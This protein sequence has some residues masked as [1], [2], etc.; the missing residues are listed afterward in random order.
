[1]LRSTDTHTVCYFFFRDNEEQ[2]NLAM[3]LCALLHQLF[4]HQPQLVR[5]AI[6][7]WNKT[8][9]KLVRE[10]A[11]LWRILLAAASDHQAHDITFVLDALDECQLSNQQL[12]IGLLARFCT[13]ISP[14][15]STTRRGWLKFLI[16]SRPYYGVR[17]EFQKT[18]QDLPTI[19][20][21]G[22]E[23]NSLIHQEIDLTIRT[24]VA[25]LA[26]DLGLEA[27]MLSGLEAKLLEM[28]HRTYLWL[29][30]TI[31]GIYDTFR[32][33]L[34]PIE[35]LIESLPTSVQD[36]YERTLN[37]VPEQQRG[38]VQKILQIVVGSRRPLTIQEMAIALGIA[39]STHSK[40]V[41]DAKLDP[42]RLENNVRDWCGLFVFINH[43]RIHLIH[44]TAKEFLICDSG[45]TTS[46]SGW[47]HCL[48]P[49]GI[50]KTMTQICVELLCLED[51]WPTGESIVRKL[52][53][54]VRIDEI[55]DKDND[56][57]S[58]LSYAAEH[59]PYHLRGADIL[60]NEFIMAKISQLCDTESPLYRMWFSIFWR[61]T[62]VY[63]EE[64]QMNSIR[65][66]ALLG[67]ETVLEWI[68]RS[69][70]NYDINECDDAGRTALMWASEGGHEKVVRILLDAGAD[71]NAQGG[72]YGNALQ[73]ASYHGHEKVM[74]ILLDVGTDVNA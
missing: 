71:V 27:K 44:Q 6:P 62:H 52:K 54:Y 37:R 14:F 63:D 8:G 45:S 17:A 70:K 11:E 16:T 20:I 33:S 24:M 60:T 23:E 13:Q 74:Q 51:S 55:L 31:R 58:L 12:L 48:E 40:C 32:N 22:E 53:P 41:H 69:K 61:S 50:E 42:V 18:L 34:R 29:Y 10:V 21:Y 59:W 4:T 38:N 39:I 2:D 57:E 46:L 56:V 9:D 47:K 30:L 68:L 7:A 25:K 67:H 43:S 35:A 26:M 65:L 1:V 36:A 64:P 3:A 66:A 19:R 28:E 49:R 73:A 72:E 5:Y 15:S